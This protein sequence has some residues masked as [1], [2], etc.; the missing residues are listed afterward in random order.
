MYEQ[1]ALIKIEIAELEARAKEL[2]PKII[3]EIK[4][5]KAL[6][7]KYANPLG[8]FSVT[9]LKKWS[10]P[11]KTLALGEKFKAQKA[12]DESTGDATYTE[13]LSLRF[14]PIKL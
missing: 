7:L 10:Y 5:N 6:Q 13:E 14:I 8:S 2:A 12:K 4:G 9:P 11:A 3:E 1:Y